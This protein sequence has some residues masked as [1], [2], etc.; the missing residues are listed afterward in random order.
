MFRF[1]TYYLC[2]CILNT[3]NIFEHYCANYP[4]SPVDMI[5]ET[6]LHAGEC[7]KGGADCTKTEKQ[8]KLSM[9]SIY[10]TQHISYRYI[11][12]KYLLNPGTTDSKT[13]IYYLRTD[14]ICNLPHFLTNIHTPHL[15]RT[16]YN[17]SYSV[18]NSI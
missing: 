2:L 1:Y 18:A 11:H 13:F 12:Y 6:L 14:Y 8:S 17:C 4:F 10:S 9:Y 5:L 7:G 15:L 16:G 3:S